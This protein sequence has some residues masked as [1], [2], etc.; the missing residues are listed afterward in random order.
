MSIVQNIKK[1]INYSKKNGYKEA[2][3]AAWE[4]VTAKYYADYTYTAPSEEE[5]KLQ[6]DDKK[7]VNVKFSIITTKYI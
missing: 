2:F 7:V 4:R 3:C 6:A 5:L 1:T